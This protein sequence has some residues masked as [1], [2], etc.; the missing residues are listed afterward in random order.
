MLQSTLSKQISPRGVRSGTPCSQRMC[1]RS[2][3]EHARGRAPDLRLDKSDLGGS[4]IVEDRA[5]APREARL[6]RGR[7][8]RIGGSSMSARPAPPRSAA[9]PPAPPGLRGRG[10]QGF[11]CRA[12]RDLGAADHAPSAHGR[13]RGDRGRHARVARHGG[14]PARRARR[15]APPGP[16]RI[17]Q[18][19]AGRRPKRRAGCSANDE[20]ELSPGGDPIDFGRSDQPKIASSGGDGEVTPR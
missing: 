3:R 18:A 1:A 16:A 4:S 10:A 20:G 8:R 19:R 9:T 14:R 12:R 15:C 5:R 7:R 11:P 6:W 2:V 13:R 17:R